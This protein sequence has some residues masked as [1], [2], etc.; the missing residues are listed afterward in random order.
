MIIKA[1]FSL[2]LSLFSFLLGLFP[3]IPAFPDEVSQVLATVKE[4]IVSGMGILNSFM[5]GQVIVVMLGISVGLFVAYE[6]YI[7]I[8]WVVKKIPLLGIE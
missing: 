2:V 3:S 4:Y 5:Y 7:F 1:L 6:V 8:M